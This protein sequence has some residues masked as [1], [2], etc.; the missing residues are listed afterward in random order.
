MATQVTHSWTVPISPSRELRLLLGGIKSWA[1]R[2]AGGQ[3]RRPFFALLEGEPGQGK[4]LLLEA[5]RSASADLGLQVLWGASPIE[6]VVPGGV[7]AEVIE[8]IL[9]AALEANGKRRELGSEPQAAA[10]QTKR[11]A[12]AVVERFGPALRRFFPELPWPEGLAEL[13]SLPPDLERAR[14]IDSLVRAILAFS[15]RRPTLLV[16]E[17]VEHGGALAREIG[18]HLLRVLDCRSSARRRVPHRLLVITSAAC[19]RDQ[20]H[21]WTELVAPRSVAFHIE[22][23]GYSREE[24]QDL[25]QRKLGKDLALSSRERLH[26]LTRGNVRL[27]HWWIE[28]ARQSGSH[29]LE[30]VDAP[31]EL[32]RL[33]SGCFR[34]LSAE[35][36]D[37]LFSLAVLGS[38]VPKS[39][40]IR[41]ARGAES[42]EDAAELLA[43]LQERGWIRAWRPAHAGGE[44]KLF[45]D[46]EVGAIVLECAGARG[47]RLVEHHLL[48]AS[49]YLEGGGTPGNRLVR[50][51]H[52]LFRARQETRSRR[53]SRRAAQ[54]AQAEGSLPRLLDVGTQA[55]NFLEA[56]GC[57]HEALEIFE[58]VLAALR[59]A[60]KEVPLEAEQRLACL[61]EQTGNH[62]EALEAQR[63]LLTRAAGAGA[64]AAVLRVMGDLHGLLGEPAEQ[65]DCYL[66][67]L[68]LMAEAPASADCCRL[69]AALARAQLRGGALEEGLS[70][71]ERGLALLPAAPREIEPELAEI[72]ASRAELHIRRGEYAAAIE[73][74]KRLLAWK[75]SSGD[76]L[77]ILESW[78]GLGRLHFQRGEM[79]EARAWCERHLELAKQCGSRYLQAL[80]LERF[81]SQ[82][83]ERRCLAEG[84]RLL[85]RA[86][87]I[88]EELGKLSEVEQV[89]ARLLELELRR[90]R[91]RAAARTLESYTERR[92]GIRMTAESYSGGL[93]TPESRPQSG[94]ARKDESS[95]ALERQARRRPE[96]LEPE[97]LLR[98]VELWLG[99]GKLDSVLQLIDG[100][101]L[102]EDLR[103]LGP[104]RASLLQARGQ[105][106]RLKGDS[107]L[108]LDSYEQSLQ[109]LLGLEEVG[110]VAKAYLEVGAILRE[111]GRL[112]RAYDYTLR[113]L[114]HHLE[115]GD[116]RRLLEALVHLA[117]FLVEM[118]RLHP[119]LL[120]AAIARELAAQMGALRLELIACRLSA[121][122]LSE[123]GEARGAQR[124]FSLAVDLERRLAQPVESCRLRLESGWD[125]YRRREHAR[126]L[127]L[128]REGIELARVMGLKHLLGD[129]L[130]LV[131]VIE[132]APENPKKN[133]LRALEVLEQALAGAELAR[134]PQLRWHV[135]RAMAN[136]YAG[137]GKVELAREFARRAGEVQRFLF[138]SLPP[139]LQKL[140]W[141]CRLKARKTPGIATPEGPR[142][143][144]GV[145]AL[146][147]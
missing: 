121:R 80:G 86:R 119:G 112:A 36:R 98:V 39:L 59:E 103:R 87:R 8:Q 11:A 42:L 67:A 126:A 76:V 25:A 92:F 22:V 61:L 131:G 53:R 133:F 60:G 5:L 19:A 66:G 31:V 79:L 100:A 29:G 48:A 51:L 18:T 89:E 83:G 97:D 134:R 55:A 90:G 93:E 69:H 102:R 70:T 111:R 24:I 17:G 137:R 82:L 50:A 44:P 52:H 114:R 130:H 138:G 106:A 95:R 10:V 71:C 68:D 88:F 104:V 132:S 107:D 57:H 91:F 123:A 6:P 1:Q 56:S 23:R 12:A 135:L 63:H 15:S 46:R 116:A 128:A 101:L 37:L 99:G 127:E 141:G 32:C 139:E 62:R 108:A 125:R 14:L 84:V 38:P 120:V 28:A 7:F 9:L 110:G 124:A 136:V 77:G 26:R 129:L 73:I 75:E 20:R 96:R 64:R 142:Q 30:L 33:A 113:G 105:A 144:A 143:D 35:E 3:G 147:I 43:G 13:P 85:L 41:H 145:L 94:G 81:G 146:E 115:C 65:K 49:L 140:R 16:L 72:Y 34:G 45:M 117:E 122:A 54:P 27:V 118:G 40:L 4:S 78:R 21:H 58:S 74:E 47:P 109:S 2:I